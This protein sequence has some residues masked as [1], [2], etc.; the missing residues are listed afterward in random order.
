MKFLIVLLFTILYIRPQDWVPGFVGLPVNWM[1]VPL[2][3]LIGA[4]THQSAGTAFRSPQV[5][6]LALY[7]AVIFIATYLS[8]DL[9][10]GIE[11][12]MLFFKHGLVF[13]F[14]LM[15]VSDKEKLRFAFSAMLAFSM[16]LAFQACLEG[17]TGRAWGGMTPFPGYA[18]IRVRWYGDWD[19][20]NV[21]GLLFTLSGAIAIEYAF[22]KGSLLTRLWGVICFGMSFAGIF[23]TN[24]RGAFLGVIAAVAFYL[25][26]RFRWWVAILLCMGFLLAI[27]FV[28]PSRVSSISSEEASAGERVWLWEQGLDMLM[29]NPLFGVGRDQFW[30]NVDLRLIAHNNF[31]QVFAE[32]GLTGFFCFL[33]LLWLGF[34]SALRVQKPENGYSPELQSAGRI[35]SSLMVAYCA[36]TFFV[37]MENDLLFVVLGLSAAIGVLA[38]LE[39]PEDNILSVDWRDFVMVGA[40]AFAIIAAVWVA[41]VKEVI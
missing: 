33:M 7:L 41:A 6:T 1:I 2:G 25:R 36:T 29:E 13:M 26:S 31:V 19:G 4:S 23:Y 10:T 17:I 22:R 40:G 9:L 30:K 39:K 34:R 14:V 37:V 28:G 27:M 15:V 8:V 24:S 16:F 3:I 18:E 21:F 12:F 35:M 11:E 38:K 32:T 5:P 20:P